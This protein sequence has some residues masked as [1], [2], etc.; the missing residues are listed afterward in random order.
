MP[1][2]RLALLSAFWLARSAY[3]SAVSLYLTQKQVSAIVPRAQ[4]ESVFAAVGL[5]SSIAALFWNPL[6]GSLSDAWL[7]PNPL[8]R[9]HPFLVAGTLLHLLSLGLL[10]LLSTLPYRPDAHPALP[11]VVLPLLAL[12][13]LLDSLFDALAMAPYS[14]LIPECVPPAQFGAASGWM[15][16]ASM[17]GTLLGAVGTGL[18]LDSVSLPAM[19][20]AQLLLLCVGM[21]LTV[22]SNEPYKNRIIFQRARRAA[23]ANLLLAQRGS[24]AIATFPSCASPDDSAYVSLSSLSSLSSSLSS[25]SPLHSSSST[26]IVLTP[27]K[28]AS[29][30]LSSSSSSSASSSPTSSLALLPNEIPLDPPSPKAAVKLITSETSVVEDV[31]IV[32]NEFLAPFRADRNFLWIFL[33]RFFYNLGFDIV[34]SFFYFFLSD[35]VA[36]P[37]DFFGVLS[38]GDDFEG[39]MGLFMAFFLLGAV[40]S[41][42]GSGVLS[43]RMGR[44]RILYLSLL[45]QSISTATMLWTSS[46]QLIAGIMAPLAGFGYGA[47]VSVDWALASDAFSASDDM[48]R[49]MGIWHTLSSEV[50]DVVGFP[51][52]AFLMDRFRHTGDEIGITFLGHRMVLIFVILCLSLIHI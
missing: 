39:A 37:Y 7:T 28:H 1:H 25:N 36:P 33:S 24:D 15:G 19:Y 16:Y 12:A 29:S 45:L 9:R 26:S 40:L 22:A 43:D 18:L 41:S 44:K 23:R 10:A 6:C 51:V 34:S 49:D 17:L 50:P 11:A 30:S 8:G 52:A 35:M 20:A 46:F 3:Q 31:W 47:Y 32:L 5:T 4:R 48:A 38:L 14:A 21:A 27:T 13:L 2:W 42:L